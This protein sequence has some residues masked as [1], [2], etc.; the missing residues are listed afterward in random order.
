ML[1]FIR[2]PQIEGVIF[3]HTKKNFEIS[4]VNILKTMYFFEY[5]PLLEHLLNYSQVMV[6][7]DI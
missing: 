6:L 5:A 7:A 4:V 1:E 3:F 2:F